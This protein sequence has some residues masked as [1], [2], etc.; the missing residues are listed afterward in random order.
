[1]FSGSVCCA[2]EAF[3]MTRKTTSKKENMYFMLD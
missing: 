2:I 3:E 1:V